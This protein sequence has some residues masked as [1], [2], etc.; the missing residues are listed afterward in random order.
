MPTECAMWS[1]DKTF[2]HLYCSLRRA[3]AVRV[4]HRMLRRLILGCETWA[5]AWK[6]CVG[7]GRVNWQCVRRLFHRHGV[8]Q[9]C[10][11]SGKAR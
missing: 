10:N 2:G 5:W 11:T 1:L 7:S 8:L 4:D 9:A 3:T 6:M